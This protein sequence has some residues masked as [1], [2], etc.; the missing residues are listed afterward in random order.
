[1]KLRPVLESTICSADKRDW[2]PSSFQAFVMEID[3]IVSHGQ[4]VDHLLLFKGHSDSRW[5]LDSTFVRYVK[6]YVLG[7]S[8]MSRFR[9]DYRH[10]AEYQRLIGGLL[11]YKFE[12]QTSPRAE[13]FRLAQETGVDPWFEWMKRIQQYPEEDIGSLHGSFL[14]IPMKLAA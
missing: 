13:L 12:T 1:M 11:L 10:S 4:K 3:S 8:P 9:V 7:I 2:R 6:K 5:L 14:P